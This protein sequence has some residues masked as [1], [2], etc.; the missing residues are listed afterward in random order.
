VA[1]YNKEI[2]ENL[3]AYK[4]SLIKQMAERAGLRIQQIIPGF[5]SKTHKVGVNEQDLV[6]FEAV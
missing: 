4:I 3:I 5:W 6:L 2:P 1:L